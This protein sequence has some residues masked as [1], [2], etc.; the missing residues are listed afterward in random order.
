MNNTFYPSAWADQRGPPGVKEN[1]TRCY[2]KNH[3]VV[4]VSDNYHS[5]KLFYILAMYFD[6]HY[7]TSKNIVM[8][9]LSGTGRYWI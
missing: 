9:R 5:S 2:K 1:I 8:Y 6:Y 4:L 3:P 7:Y